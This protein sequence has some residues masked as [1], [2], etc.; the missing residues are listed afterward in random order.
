MNLSPLSLIMVGALDVLVV[1]HLFN[2]LPISCTSYFGKFMVA[3]L[4]ISSFFVIIAN[5]TLVM[6]AILNS[7]EN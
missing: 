7:F 1:H 2:E 3:V 6:V 5:F 4:S